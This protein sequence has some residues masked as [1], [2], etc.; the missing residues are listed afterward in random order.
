M[1]PTVPTERPDVALTSPRS[2]EAEL[3]QKQ[4]DEEMTKPR[5]PPSPTQRRLTTRE[6]RRQRLL[7]RRRR[8]SQPD[9]AQPR[10]EP[11]RQQERQ[12]REQRV[13]RA[14]RSARAP[15]SDDFEVGDGWVDRGAA[16]RWAC[17]GP[18]RYCVTGNILT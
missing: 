10:Q 12:E 15:Y 11:G 7:R 5:R 3:E 9:A 13:T 16:E 18:V 8:P 1:P 2:L 6:R 4:F 14:A 17:R